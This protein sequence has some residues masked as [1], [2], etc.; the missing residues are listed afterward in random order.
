MQNIGFTSI[1][2]IISFDT[3]HYSHQL[4]TNIH[5]DECGKKFICSMAIVKNRK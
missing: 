5:K 1:K 3:F 2:T 4:L